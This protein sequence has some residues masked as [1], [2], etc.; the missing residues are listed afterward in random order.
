MP[1]SNKPDEVVEDNGQ[2]AT[3]TPSLDIEQL[4]EQLRREHEMYLRALADFDNFRRR[5]ERDRAEAA[6]AASAKLSSRCW[7]RWMVSDRALE[8]MSD[9]SP[10]VLEGLQ[11]I[12]R[13][14]LAALER[15][16]VVPF[17]SV[18]DPFNPELHEA[19]AAEKTDAL[20]PEW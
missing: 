6:I 15:E 2:V 13:K 16:G 18:G 11:A 10:G 7:M 9:A 17:D 12:R 19:V 1:N 8:Q 14:M 3:A 20:N 5:V 4:Q